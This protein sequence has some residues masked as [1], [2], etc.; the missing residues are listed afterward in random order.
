[1]ATIHSSPN[2]NYITEIEVEE[3]R[4]YDFCKR[5]LDFSIA[6]AVLGLLSPLWLSLAILIKITSPGPVFY[7]GRVIG[8]GGQEF[9]Y[10]KFRSMLV[11]NDNDEHRNFIINYVKHDRPHTMVE[12]KVTAQVRPVFKLVNDRR[13]TKIGK[14]IRKF[15]FDEVPQLINVLRGEMSIVGPRPPVVYEYELYDKQALQRLSVL[16]GITGWAQI[17]A[18]G[19]ASF[20]KMLSLDMEYIRKRSIWFDF[21]IMLC[22]PLAMLKGA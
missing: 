16:P 5:W 7:K 10:Y 11:N 22:T 9:T 15:S 6:L 13:V 21:K 4:I 17:R 19:Q 14:F 18:R 12:D 2:V 3:K 8:K 20:S 1:M